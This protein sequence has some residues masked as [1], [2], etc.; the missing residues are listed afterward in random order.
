MKTELLKRVPANPQLPHDY[1][2]QFG[3]KKRDNTTKAYPFFYNFIR[4]PYQIGTPDDSFGSSQVTGIYR[5]TAADAEGPDGLNIVPGGILDIPVVMD[6]DTNFHLLYTKFG[7]FRVSEFTLTTLGAGDTFS[8]PTTDPFIDGQSLVIDTLTDTTGPI[9]GQVYYVITAGASTFQISLTV[10]GAAI[11]LT[12]N[13]SAIV[14]RQGGIYGSREY[15]L[16]PYTNSDP[17][18]PG[19]GLLN[20]NANAR[21]PYWTELDVSLYLPSSGSRDVYGGFQREPIGGVTREAPIPILDLQG[22]QDG[23]GCLKTP[24]QL[25]KSATVLIRVRSRCAYPLRVYG[26]LFGYKITL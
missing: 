17:A 6:N 4:Y 16:V 12:T 9:V 19:Q 10:G 7:A 25:T 15:L 23:I 20:A 1:A 18:L 5:V 26:H 24:Y 13:G 8:Q 22:S 14:R 21:I 11:S 3:N 2:V